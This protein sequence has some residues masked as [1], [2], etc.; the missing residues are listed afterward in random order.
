MARAVATVAAA[1]RR[2]PRTVIAAAI[3]RVTS[4]QLFRAQLPFNGLRST[5]AWAVSL[6]RCQIV[7]QVD[8][9][10][11]RPPARGL[12]HSTPPASIESI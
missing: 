1:G 11:S 7:I 12:P 4:L 3:V 9:D 5:G 8:P 6:C 2:R 10:N